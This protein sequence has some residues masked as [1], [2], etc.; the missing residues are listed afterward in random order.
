M[1]QEGIWDDGEF[2]EQKISAVVHD[3]FN[4]VH[5]MP[6]KNLSPNI[7]G[8]LKTLK[9]AVEEGLISEEE[10]AAKRKMILDSL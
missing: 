7:A 4:S 5:K 10:A 3:L 8:K 9:K 1:I 6:N 2:E